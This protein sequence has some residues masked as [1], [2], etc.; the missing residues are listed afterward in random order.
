MKAG[1]RSGVSVKRGSDH[2][3]P[4][5]PHFRA[6]AKSVPKLTAV[7]PTATRPHKPVLIGNHPQGRYSEP[8]PGAPWGQENRGPP[9][10]T[11]RAM[12]SVADQESRT[13]AETRGARAAGSGIRDCALKSPFQRFDRK[14]ATPGTR[15]RGPTGRPRRRGTWSSPRRPARRR[16]PCTPR[17]RRRAE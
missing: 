7:R 11:P 4:T 9:T 2:V 5:S 14:G 17:P 8:T 3:L 13:P 6:P 10:R 15:C 12:K 16:Q 1:I